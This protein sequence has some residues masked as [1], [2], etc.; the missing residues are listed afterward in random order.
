MAQH[1]F[2]YCNGVPVRKHDKV[3][4]DRA[5]TAWIKEILAPGTQEAH[6]YSCQE[7]GLVVMFQDGGIQVW[8]HADED[9][10]LV[11][12]GAEDPRKE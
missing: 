3:L 5:Y 1:Q 6:D 2:Y 10:C 12:R 11:E 4:I 7:G 9:I 8:P